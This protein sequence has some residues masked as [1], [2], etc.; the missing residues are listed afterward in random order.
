MRTTPEHWPQLAEYVREVIGRFADDERVIAWD[1]YNET[2]P[3]HRPLLKSVFG[4][5]REA[6]PSQPLVACWEADDLCDLPT[7]HCYEDAGGEKFAAVLEEA[8]ESGRPALC[9]E[10][11][12]RNYGNT[13]EK[14]LPAFRERGIGWYVWGLVAG[15]T[16]TRFPWGWP[17]GGPEPPIWFHDLLYPDGTPYDEGEIALLKEEA[18][19]PD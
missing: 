16:Q 17:A 18:G 2:K 6:D 7:F 3:E 5:A 19:L 9:T 15:A 11:L 4:W 12:A 14:L 1:L 10:C 13:L 8:T